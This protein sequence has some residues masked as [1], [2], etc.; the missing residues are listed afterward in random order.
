MD[1]LVGLG[2]QVG[3][4]APVLAGLEGVDLALAVD[5]HLERGRLDPAGGQAGPDLAPQ[6]RRQLV[7]DDP[8]DH[9]AG[10]LGVDQAV[11]DVAGVGEGPPDGVG[12]DLGEGDPAGRAGGQLGRLGDVPGDRLA[13]PVGVGGEEHLVGRLGGLADAGD[14]LL[15]LLGHLV[16]DRDAAVDVHGKVRLGQ[17]TD[18]AH[19]GDHV[20]VLA[21]VLADGL[22]LGRRLDHDQVA[23]QWRSFVSRGEIGW[24]GVVLPPTPLLCQGVNSLPYSR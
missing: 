21:Q 23:C 2:G 24:N 10:L 13:L 5:D 14:D 15:A 8:V 6:H 17:V 7:A 4:E 3:L 11:V 9:P 1:A 22:R 18:V 12:G 16:G 20:V 19:G